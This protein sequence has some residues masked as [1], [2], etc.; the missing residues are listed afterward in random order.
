VTNEGQPSAFVQAWNKSIEREQRLRSRAEKAEAA[1]ARV[2]QQ[3]ESWRRAYERDVS[4]L[5]VLAFVLAA[6]LIWQMK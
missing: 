4:L 2:T 5:V 6:A 3:R 1:L